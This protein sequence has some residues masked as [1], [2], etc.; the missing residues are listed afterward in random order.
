MSSTAQATVGEARDWI[1]DAVATDD[2]NLLLRYIN[3]IRETII[4]RYHAQSWHLSGER[5]VRMTRYCAPCPNYRGPNW[6]GFPMPADF[7]NLEAVLC[8][9]TPFEMRSAFAALSDGVSGYRGHGPRH[10]LGTYPRQL[11]KYDIQGTFPL[12]KDPSAPGLLK[13]IGSA[14]DQGKFLTIHYTDVAGVER[15]EKLSIQ[16]CWQ[17]TKYSVGRVHGIAIDAHDRSVIIATCD[18]E[19]LSEYPR[20]INAPAYRRVRVAGLGCGCE[21]LQLRIVGALKYVDVF[22]DHEIIEPA[23]PRIY[24]ELGMYLK[25]NK[26]TLARRE[27]E[28]A[29]IHLATGFDLLEG[30]MRRDRGQATQVV[31][32]PPET[33]SRQSGLLGNRRG[34]GYGR[35]AIRHR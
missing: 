7:Q 10:G 32:E 18:G 24:E 35:N 8:D 11:T 34:R 16:D 22:D 33:L 26:R 1:R 6:W 25:L 9:E 5:C 21:G 3:R 30:L 23:T 29:T 4:L 27:R 12:F 20:G 14:C 15:S 31:I 28:E 19:T 2:E 13:V 17:M